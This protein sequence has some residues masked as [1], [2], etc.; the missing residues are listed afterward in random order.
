MRGDIK[1][2][3]HWTHATTYC[4]RY[5]CHWGS[6]V[7]RMLHASTCATSSC[8]LHPDLLPHSSQLLPNAR[9]AGSSWLGCDHADLALYVTRP[10][11]LLPCTYTNT[12]THTHTHP[13][14][15]THTLTHT[16]LSKS[17]PN[18]PAL[19]GFHS[20]ISSGNPTAM[21]LQLTSPAAAHCGPVHGGL[22]TAALLSGH[23]AHQSRCQCK[24]DGHRRCACSL[25]LLA[26]QGKG[27]PRSAATLPTLSPTAHQRCYILPTATPC[28]TH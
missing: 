1:T 7:R 26:E 4:G 27:C 15:I 5:M 21:H 24:S 18:A 23:A 11:A 10:R 8:G 17:D 9:Q 22:A 19:L 20:C 25:L 13:H 2:L 28:A 14:T 16:T 3:W 12:H 6:H